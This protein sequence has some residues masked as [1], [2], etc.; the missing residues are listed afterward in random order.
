[1]LPASNSSKLFRMRGQPLGR[2][3]CAE[4]LDVFAAEVQ[5]CFDQ[6]QDI[7]QTRMDLSGRSRQPAAEQLC[8]R[9]QLEPV[10]AAD[11]LV[12]RLGLGEIELAVE[13]STGRKLAR[14][15]GPQAPG[16]QVLHEG[17]DD[18]GAGTDVQLGQV[19]AG[20]GVRSEEQIKPSVHRQRIVDPHGA[21]QDRGTWDFRI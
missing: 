14:S 3:R 21:G 10:G 6:A 9:I 4:E 18:H 12:D 1:M 8:G 19:L 17:R 20:V 2:L 11:D 7:Q 16:Q 13:V 5:P 15:G